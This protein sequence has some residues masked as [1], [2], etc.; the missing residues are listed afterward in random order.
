L[1]QDFV[2]RPKRRITNDLAWTDQVKALGIDESAS[3][4]YGFCHARAPAIICR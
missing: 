1:R 2:G 4:I 3:D